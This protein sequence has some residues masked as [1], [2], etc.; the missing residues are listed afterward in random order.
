VDRSSLVLVRLKISVLAKSKKN[1]FELITIQRDI[2]RLA[3][4]VCLLIHNSRT[5]DT[6]KSLRGSN[7][8][9]HRSQDARC[10]SHVHTY[11][12]TFMQTY[13][14]CVQAVGNIPVDTDRVTACRRTWHDLGAP[15]K[16]I[17]H[18]R[19]QLI[20]LNRDLPSSITKATE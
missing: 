16:T 15:L 1:L 18:Q 9:G 20:L 5:N 2:K 6:F 4:R 13:I 14:E 8:R 11:I 17:V 3:S 12:H 19:M 7:Y 10:H